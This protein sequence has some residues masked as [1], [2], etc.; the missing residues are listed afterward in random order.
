M[1]L[2]ALKSHIVY[3]APKKNNNGGCIG[4]S[5]VIGA[6]IWR[7]QGCRRNGQGHWLDPV[8]GAEHG[9]YVQRS[10]AAPVRLLVHKASG[11]WQLIPCMRNEI[12]NIF[13]GF[14]CGRLKVGF[15]LWQRSDWNLEMKCP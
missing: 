14:Y 6:I 15:V 7:R 1:P 8:V 5:N 12:I 13:L 9:I 4:S 10:N 11:G 3:I 2:L